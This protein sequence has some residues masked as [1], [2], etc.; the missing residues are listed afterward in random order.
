MKMGR[1]FF[2]RESK[3]SQWNLALS[4]I[5]AKPKAARLI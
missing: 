2:G 4:A 5:G 3:V 1:G